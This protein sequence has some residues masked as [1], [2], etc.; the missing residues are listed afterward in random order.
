MTQDTE[1]YR[2]LFESHP[3]AMAIWDPATGRI[4]AVNDAAVRQ[5]G[6]TPE[7][8]CRLTVDR[9]VHPDDWPRL[10]DRLATMPPGHVGG[11]TF[12]HLRRDGSVIEAEMTGHELLLDGKPTRVVMALDVTERRRL[13]ERLRQAQRMEAVGQ[14]AG[15]IAHDFNNLLMVINGFSELLLARLPPGEERDA[16]QQ[17]RT[18]GDRAAALTKQLLAFASPGVA[19]PE[20]LNLADVISAMLPMLEGSLGLHVELAFD[21]TAREPW[22]EADRAQLEQVLVNLAV[23]AYDAMP[24]GGRLTIELADAPGDHPEAMASPHG[25]LLLSVSDTGRGIAEEIRERVFLPFFTT[26]ADRGSSGLGLATVFATVRA[27]GGR[28]WVEGA[29]TPGTTICLLLPRAATPADAAGSASAGPRSILVAEDEP[30]VLT[31]I[32][33]VLS[34]AGYTVH[35]AS[36]GSEAIAIVGAHGADIDLLVSDAV[37]P[38][39]AG[40]E[41]ARQLRIE[42][43]GLPILFVSG[44]A[45]EAFERDWAGEA[46]VD[47][48]LKPFE[49]AELLERVGR[50]L[51]GRRAGDRRGEVAPVA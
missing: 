2:R 9:L 16:A 34:S 37:M 5:Y 23:N 21:V 39:M 13:E 38:G 50:L 20:V 36:T 31:L 10:H 22:V 29:P 19:R 28:I 17:V 8:A 46:A 33:R 35:S 30:A 41:L 47:L 27:C 1:A 49:V 42:R 15:G 6:Y 12:R 45:G 44:W 40:M 43:P 7:E 18:A 25:M 32:E 26:K 4:L 48:L 51:E 14:L 11:E 24:D 3:V